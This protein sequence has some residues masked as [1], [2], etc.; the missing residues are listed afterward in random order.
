[1]SF[2]LK[3]KLD[4]RTIA[5][6]EKVDLPD[7]CVL[8]VVSALVVLKLNVQAVLNTHLHLQGTYISSHTANAYLARTWPQQAMSLR[9]I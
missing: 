7:N 4:V 8:Q 2:L 1:M 3:R 5:H 6:Q 9:E